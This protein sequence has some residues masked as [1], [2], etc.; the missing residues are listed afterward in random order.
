[1]QK[2]KV[3]EM[4]LD[5]DIAKYMPQMS[6]STVETFAKVHA[7]ARRMRIVIVTATLVEVIVSIALLI[8]YDVS[9][10]P[11]L[12]SF[13]TGLSIIYIGYLGFLWLRIYWR[14]RSVRYL[15][16]E[17]WWWTVWL[18][19]WPLGV[20]SEFTDALGA[21]LIVTLLALSY[22]L[23]EWRRHK[24]SLE[25]QAERGQWESLASTN[26]REMAF[27]RFR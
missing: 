23:Q 19:I 20:I 27:G 5:S 14:T 18:L 9:K 24:M 17:H 21:L 10:A 16:G 22:P 8:L 6:P 2:S 15:L 4:L 11:L 13:I 25:I 7:F 26:L 12:R 1:M 3:L